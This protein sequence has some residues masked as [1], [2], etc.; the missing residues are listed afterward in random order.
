MNKTKRSAVSILMT[1]A[2]FFMLFPSLGMAAAS[3]EREQNVNLMTETMS[4]DETRGLYAHLDVSVS[5]DNNYI[6]GQVKNV[7]TL[8]P[9]T[10]VVYLE[11]YSSEVYTEDHTQM[12]LEGS[13]MTY[14]LNQGEILEVRV[15]TGGRQRYWKTRIKYKFDDRDWVE[16]E[17]NSYLY[18]A[19]GECLS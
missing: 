18:S 1:F 7:F 5:S 9:S 10:I 12:T 11:L 8:F 3:T 15:S 17:T 2:L 4:F 13:N 19:D 6:L 16:S 14:D